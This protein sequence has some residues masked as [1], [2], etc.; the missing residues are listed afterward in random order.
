MLDFL[1]PCGQ[2]VT[3]H[4]LNWVASC[5]IMCYRIDMEFASC[6]PYALGHLRTIGVSA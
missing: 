6:I 5:A 3:V 2:S 1:N 4:G